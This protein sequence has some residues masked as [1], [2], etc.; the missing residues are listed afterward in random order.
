[1]YHSKMQGVTS[2]SNDL[3]MFNDHFSTYEKTP[4]TSRLGDTTDLHITLSYHLVLRA[5]EVVHP[6][7]I[8]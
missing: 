4:V 1:M 2:A 8:S 6:V 7:L 3:V 5:V